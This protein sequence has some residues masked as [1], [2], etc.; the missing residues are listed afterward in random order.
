MERVQRI[1]GN[2]ELGEGV[3]KADLTTR[4]SLSNGRDILAGKCTTCHDLRTILA[5][6][7]TGKRWLDCVVRM[8]EKPA[9]GDPIT[10]EDIPVVTAYLIAIT[11]DIQ[12]SRKKLKAVAANQAE[13]AA[14][15][16]SALAGDAPVAPA[17]AAATKE[18][19]EEACAECHELDTVEDLA[20]TNSPDLAGWQSVI[21][22]MVEEEGAEL[23]GADA[24]RIAQ[25]LTT[26]NAGN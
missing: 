7:K 14:S 13:K 11:P 9:F 8:A 19:Y 17:D 16:S 24:A 21:Q 20:T 26:A 10:A 1:L 3:V 23:D 22:R 6:P 18:L 15:V 25:Y 5:K 2:L 4:S 12:Q